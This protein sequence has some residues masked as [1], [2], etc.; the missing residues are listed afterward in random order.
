MRTFLATFLA[1]LA[2]SA[3]MA[4]TQIEVDCAFRASTDREDVQRPIPVLCLNDDAEP[5]PPTSIHP[6]FPRRY[7]RD[8]TELTAPAPIA[9]PMD[10]SSPVDRRD[11]SGR[12]HRWSR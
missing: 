11:R 7:T 10:V 8:S 4:G 5:Q 6:P 9:V 1:V 3:S 12:R 2:A